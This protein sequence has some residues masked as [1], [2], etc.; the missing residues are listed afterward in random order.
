[1]SIA[2]LILAAGA[3]RRLGQPKQLVLHYGETLL[4]RTMRL[5]TLSA[6]Q[7]V[8]VILGAFADQIRSIVD[9]GNANIV[10]NLLWEQGIASSI[11][12][13]LKFIEESES[14]ATPT[15]GVLILT[16]DQPQLTEEHIVKL[17]ND[18]LTQS[19]AQRNSIIVASAY[20]GVVGTPAIFPRSHFANLHALTG[21]QGARSILRNSTCRIIS[22]EFLG[23]ELDI[24]SPE[25][26]LYLDSSNTPQR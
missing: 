6:A 2:A 14:A 11:Q 5:T 12:A 21:D 23:G 9:F 15:D 22:I 16:C 10:E 19:G 8:V 25:D 26:L 7:P 18:F 3:S 20:A 13:G 24:D 4:A 17:Q 1:M